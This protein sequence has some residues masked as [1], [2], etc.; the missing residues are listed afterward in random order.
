MSK[1]CAE[2]DFLKDCAFMER[3]LFLANQA[4]IIS[5]PNPWVGCVI[6]NQNKIVGKGFTQTPGKSHAEIIALQQAKELAKGATVYVTLEPC[7]HFGRTPPCVNALIEAGIS[8]VVIGVQDPDHHVQGK[9]IKVLSEAKIQV[10]TGILSDAISS[11]L[12]PYLYHRRTGLPY[13]LLKSA[14]SVDGRIAAKDRSSRW[15]SSPEARLDAHLQRAESQAIIVGAG[16]A[17]IDQPALTVRNTPNKPSKPPLRVILDAQ[18]QVKAKGP[19][20]DTSFAP[21]MIITTKLCSQ[22]TINL[23]KQHGVMV[24]IVSSAKNGIGVD[25]KEAMKLLG[26]KGIL[27]AMIEGGAKVLGAFLETKMVNKLILYVGGSILGS[28]GLPLFATNSISTIEESPQLQLLG[29]KV[30]GNSVRLDYQLF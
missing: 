14:V 8:R 15:I 13:C 11:S 2:E 18:G 16:T 24:E 4:R 27:Q 22:E 3:A 6:V 20:F 28:E 26:K 25:L 1:N 9:G 10:T 5:P 7:A 21:T 12:A 30:L 17:C 23:W 19:L 29:T